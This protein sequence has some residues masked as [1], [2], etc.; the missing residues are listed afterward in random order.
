MD[1]DVRQLCPDKHL[2]CTERQ[3][4]V[5]IKEDVNQ[6]HNYIIEHGYTGII[7]EEHVDDILGSILVSIWNKRVL[8]LKEFKEGLGL[9][10]L[11]AFLSHSPVAC[12]PLFVK[13]HIGDVDANYLAGLFR[14]Q[15]SPEGSSRKLVE[16]RVVHHFQ[17]FLFT[18]EDD[19]IR[20]YSTPMAWNY[21][22]SQLQDKAEFSAGEQFHSSDL[23]ASG[24]MSWLAD[25]PKTKGNE[26]PKSK[27]N[28][29]VRS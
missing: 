11:A 12:K 19:N 9:Y 27:G 24:E 25:W 10:G 26:M 18:L 1:I 28:C 3:I 7:N 5:T 15:Y 13:G 14:P 23:T 17:D 8:C 22:D 20:G 4:L 21:E 6:H 2:T 16:E 29:Q